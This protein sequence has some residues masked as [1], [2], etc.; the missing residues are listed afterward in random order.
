MGKSSHPPLNKDAIKNA[1]LRS[2]LTQAEV[3]QQVAALCAEHG[4]KFDRSSLSLIESGD[5]KRPAPK[6]IP[7]LAKVLGMTPDEMF[8][9]EEA[10]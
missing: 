5:V 7:A 10:A 4:I 3:A 8:A 9:A 1:R 6:L 2:F